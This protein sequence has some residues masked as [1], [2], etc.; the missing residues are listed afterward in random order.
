MKT[1]IESPFTMSESDKEHIHNKI[2][3]LIKYEKRMT[4]V[5]VFFKKD[6]GNV[7]SAILS[8]IRIRVPGADVFAESSSPEAIKAFSDAYG[9]VKRQLKDRRNQLNDHRSEIK[10][11][12]AIVNDNI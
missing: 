2:D 9:A 7:P 8:E 4:Q 3:D 1:T 10:K 6:D 5:N 11:I 12:N